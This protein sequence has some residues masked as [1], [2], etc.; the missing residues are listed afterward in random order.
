[1]MASRRV[2]SRRRSNRRRPAR[3][4]A[5][6][7][8]PPPS[9]G[10]PG[11]GTHGHRRPEGPPAKGA[12]K[13]RGAPHPPPPAPPPGWVEPG[14]EGADQP[15]RLG[16][17]VPAA[18]AD[19]RV[20]HGAPCI[21]EVS[22]LKVRQT[23]HGTDCKRAVAVDVDL[24]LEREL[25]VAAGRGNSE[26]FEQQRSED[27]MTTSSLSAAG[28]DR[29]HRAMA[30]RVAKGEMPG[31]VTL[32]A[33]GDEVHL[34]AIGTMT[35]GGEQPM[36]RDTIFRIASLTKPILAAAAMMLVEDGALALEEPVDRLLPELANRRV[37]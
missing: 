15:P 22:S 9:L 16:D 23:A 31:I 6:R 1:M 2:R 8:P 36:R 10:L 33:Q 19:Q 18:S 20:P 3:G 25:L 7:A 12:P 30:A 35:F 37:L 34:D 11:G 14:V 29:L 24:A 13:A 27:V 17:D 5:S 32:V 4:P 28:L 26:S 21:V